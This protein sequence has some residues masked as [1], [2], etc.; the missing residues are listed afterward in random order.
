MRA[1]LAYSNLDENSGLRPRL[2]SVMYNKSRDWQ[3]RFVP[4]F[5][6]ANFC[7][8]TLDMDYTPEVPY[9]PP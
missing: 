1:V 7:F 6:K 4:W 9:T 3:F 8:T 5:A 2:Y